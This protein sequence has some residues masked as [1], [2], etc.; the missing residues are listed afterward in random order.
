MVSEPTIME[1][2]V[3]FVD[4]HATTRSDPSW[5][6]AREFSQPGQPNFEMFGYELAVEVAVCY[7]P[8]YDFWDCL[9]L[10]SQ[11][12][13]LWKRLLPSIVSVARSIRRTAVAGIST[14]VE[15]S[16]SLPGLPIFCSRTVSR[17]TERTLK[18]IWHGSSRVWISIVRPSKPA[19][20]SCRHPGRCLRSSTAENG[21]L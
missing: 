9:N 20:R 10:R 21:S 14:F 12:R 18:S 2:S 6:A 19:S 11:P 1:G 16:F 17:V 5:E 4:G 7:R 13:F 15:E 3:K 8:R